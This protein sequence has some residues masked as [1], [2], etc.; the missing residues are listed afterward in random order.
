MTEVVTRFAPSPTG[1]LHVGGARTALFCWALARRTGGRFILRIE[2]TDQSRSSEAATGGILESLAW[3]GIDWDE[4][5]ALDLKNRA[6]W[7]TGAITDRVI[8][9]DPRGV[10]PFFQSERLDRYDAAIEELIEKDLAYPAFET[11]EELEAKR[12]AAQARKETYRYDRAALEIPRA[13]RLKRMREGEAHVV[14][15]K[16]PDEAIVVH[17]EV[18]GDVRVEA[19]QLDDFVL[20][21][22][23]GYPTYHLACVVDDEQMGVTHVLR[24]QEHLINTPRHVALQ[25]ALGYRTPVY[26]HL[27]IICN[28]DGS[29]MSKRDKD[30]ALKAHL[31]AV[32]ADEH[33][34][35]RLAQIGGVSRAE[36][37]C[38]L[39][40]TRAQ[41][42]LHV[43]DRIALALGVTLPEI[44]VRDFAESGYL[45]DVLCNYLALLGWNPG[46]KQ[47]DGTDL[48]RFSRAFLAK[49]FSIDRL[50]KKASRFDREKLLAFNAETL[51]EMPVD[52]FRAAWKRW[53]SAMIQQK[54]GHARHDSDS[55]WARLNEELGAE[56]GPALARAAQ[57]RAKTLRDAVEAVRFAL[58]ADDEVVFDEKAVRKVLHKG[59]PSGLDRLRLVRSLVEEVEPFT[60]EVIEGAIRAWCEKEGVGLGKVAQ[61][62]RVAIT[63]TTVSPGLGE[64]LA[65]VGKDGV[66]RRIER[67]LEACS[68]EQDEG[69]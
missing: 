29:K 23:D 6:V 53:A 38:W 18:L 61:P 24:G 67:C 43:L 4:G 48:E 10:G 20:R 46:M 19:E 42:P 26:A 8:G 57:P 5:P 25:R 34:Q 16:M 45:P 21:K 62:L 22:R 13:E 65:L 7:G 64:T 37:A 49:H 3:L 40:D 39:D 35:D 66:L 36:L 47:D 11:P 1:H 55:S 27:P 68:Q 44:N 69:D 51:R 63:G 2:D 60:P 9:G 14:R 32:S 50:G 58:I 12:S 59:E 28:P 54:Q 30:K 52:R 41:L 31:R 15:F 33:E 56:R 17:D